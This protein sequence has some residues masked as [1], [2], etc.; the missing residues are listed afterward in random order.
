MIQNGKCCA[1][2][3]P[4]AFQK[5][6]F[7]L[8]SF[9]FLSRLCLHAERSCLPAVRPGER[10]PPVCLTSGPKLVSSRART[11]IWVLRVPTPLCLPAVLAASTLTFLPHPGPSLISEVP[12]SLIH[13]LFKLLFLLLCL[14]VTI[15][16]EWK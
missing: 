12:L 13:H 11:E 9:N 3:K 14:T 4:R 5:D 15:A 16:T 1:R 6:L 8:D 10:K 7:L 2:D